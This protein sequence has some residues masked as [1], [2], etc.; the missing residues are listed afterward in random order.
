MGGGGY[1]VAILCVDVIGVGVP[2][3]SLVVESVGVGKVILR[4][5]ACR[6]C[7]GAGRYLVRI[8]LGLA[9][10]LTPP[11]CNLPAR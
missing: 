7:V 11:I 1:V 8:S 3:P 10:V 4:S 9:S 6:M 5:L 2:G